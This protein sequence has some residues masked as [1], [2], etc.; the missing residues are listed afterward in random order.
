M[1]SASRPHEAHVAAQFGS[2]AQ[3]Y[4]D[5]ADHAAGGDL[6]AIARLVAGRPDCCVLD[7]GCGGGHVTYA[8]APYAGDVVACDLSI[9]MLAVVADEAARRGFGNVATRQGSAENLPFS[10]AAFDMVLS[11]FSAHH[12]GDL[13][14]ALREMR[15]VVKPDG[16]AVVVDVVSPGRTALHDTFLQAVELLRDPSHVRDYSPTEWSDAL[17]AAGFEPAEPVAARLRL[18]FAPWIAR[19]GTPPS[20][21]AAIRELQARMPPAVAEH[22]AI[23]ADGSWTLDTALFEARPAPETRT[24]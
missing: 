11:R 15:R 16:L 8:A 19:I 18:A 23:E 7:L 17:R 2:N 20:L 1:T 3:A 9:E 22:F 6:L 14:Q 21:V 4:F 12:W 5:S 10:D 13:G 24:A